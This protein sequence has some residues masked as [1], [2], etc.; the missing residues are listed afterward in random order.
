MPRAEARHRRTGEA[1][2]P[3]RVDLLTLELRYEHDIVLA[4]QRTR[5]IAELLGLEAQDQTRMATAVSELA[6]NAF[7][8][9]GGGRV[10]FAVETGAGPS[11][12]LAIRVSDEGPGIA[13]LAT[14]LDGRYES[15]TGMGLGLLGARRL[16]ERFEISSEPGRGTVVEVARP[17]PPGRDTF[18]PA[19]AGRIAEALARAISVGPFEEIQQQNQ[20]LLRALDEVRARKAEV[21]RLNGELQETNRGVLALYAELDD[22]AHDL[23]RASEAKSRFLSDISHELRTPLTSVLNLSRILLDRTDGDLTSEQEHQIN[24]IRRSV[25]SVTELV[26]DLLDLAKIEAGKVELRPSSVVIAELFA[27]LRGMC[28][29]LVHTDTVHLIF[30]DASALPPVY[31]DEGRLSQILRN[32]ISNAIKFTERGEIRVEATLD[33]GDRIRFSVTDTGIGIPADAHQRIFEDY[34]QVDGPI[35]RRVA[36]TGLGLPLTRRLAGLLGGHVELT[37]VVGQGSTF[38]AVIPRSRD[39]PVP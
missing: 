30:D 1:S 33:D 9:A 12:M 13:N 29:P 8:Y 21:E 23:R 32:F 10:R 7:R 39:L 2:E 27:A 15:A 19:D 20:E 5:Q 6:R 16:S 25:S 34:T 24:L 36:G 22:R 26:N 31:T 14:I 18:A 4:R 11:S 38:S 28:R 35:Q 3:P 37:S 17:L